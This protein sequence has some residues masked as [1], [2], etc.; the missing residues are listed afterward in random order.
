MLISMLPRYFKRYGS[1][2]TAS[3]VLNACTYVG[4]ALST[5]GIAVLSQGLGWK[6]T[7]LIWVVIAVLGTAACVVCVKPWKKHFG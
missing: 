5:Y 1:A 7:I 4:S 3:G 2:S 6:G